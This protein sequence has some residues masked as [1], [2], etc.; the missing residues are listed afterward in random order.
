[1][2]NFTGNDKTQPGNNFIFYGFL[3]LY[4]TI[5]VYLSSRLNIWVDEA[6]TLN[7]TSNNFTGVINQSYGFEGQPPVYF[8]LLSFW[9]K[10]N[11]SIFFARLFSLA[12]VA[13]ATYFFYRL[14]RLIA[15]NI[16]ARWMVVVFLLNPFTVWAGMEIRLYAF[17]LFLSVAAIYFFFSF[18]N[19][20]KLKYM[21]LLIGT[22]LIGIYTQYFFAFLIA[23][24]AVS[25]LLFNGWKVFFRFCLY[26]LPVVLL[27]LPSVFFTPVLTKYVQ[28]LASHSTTK[29]ILSLLQSTQNL[30]LALQLIP[31]ERW[32]K[33]AIKIPFI[34]LLVYAFYKLYKQN[35]NT[36]GDHFKNIRKILVMIVVFVILLCCFFGLTR[37]DYQYRY[38]TIVMP[39]CVLLLSMFRIFDLLKQ[40]LIFFVI[41]IFYAALLVSN[42]WYPLKEYDYKQIAKYVE[43]IEKTKEPILFYH[44]TISLCFNYYYA[45]ESPLVPLPH[46]VRF[47]STT[48]T[49]DI[50][51]T[52][53]LRRSIEGVA[54]PSG[55]YLLVSDITELQSIGNPNQKMVNDYL[56]SHY[57][58]TL[59]TLYFGRST[60]YSFRIRRLEK[61]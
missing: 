49:S 33:W 7:T 45:G 59:D 61:R 9:R 18:Y 17:L 56:A 26:M 19:S 34:L 5:L 23:G 60:N 15:G 32:L 38:L 27:F 48:Y 14:S 1:V 21:Y 46:E 39:L 6:Y 13:L 8:I 57:T 11:S 25:L 29:Q 31:F 58:I 2:S 24:F 54:T 10:I 22:C 37:V 41:S 53:E 42:Y 55:S 40:R 28:T 4:A 43:G 16:I 50:K 52:V 36:A 12:C 51:D 3:L 20:A 47:D 44:S 30:L 35:K